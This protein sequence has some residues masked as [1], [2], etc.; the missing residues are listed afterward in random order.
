MRFFLI[1][2]VTTVTSPLTTAFWGSIQIG[3]FQIFQL[4]LFTENHHIQ[5]VKCFLSP[6]GIIE[7][8]LEVQFFAFQRI[9]R[10]FYF[11]LK[12]VLLFFLPVLKLV[13]LFCLPVLKLISLIVLD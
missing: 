3:I 4:R 13:L 6:S 9:N 12:L 2:I 7:I 1:V 10:F 8:H 11:C 5:L